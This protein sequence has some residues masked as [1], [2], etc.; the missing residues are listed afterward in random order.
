MINA[1]TTLLYVGTFKLAEYI[2]AVFPYEAVGTHFNNYYSLYIAC[3]SGVIIFFIILLFGKSIAAMNMMKKAYI[4]G[5]VEDTDGQDLVGIQKM[6]QK[7]WVKVPYLNSLY[8]TYLWS[9]ISIPFE[10]YI[11][12]AVLL[13]GLLF[14]AG[15]VLGMPTILSLVISALVMAA[16]ISVINIF[17]ARNQ[18]KITEQLP[19]VLDTMSGALQSGY[20]LLQAF[21]FTAE[22]IDP[23]ARILFEEGVREL[24]YNVP[25]EEVFE[26][27]QEKTTNQELIMVLDGLILQNKMG[28][29]IVSMLQ[30]M[31]E[32]VRQKNKLYKD[33]KVFTSQG[34]FSGLMI[35][36]LWP[37]SALVFY[38]LN[39]S[40][41]T[42]MIENPIGQMLL[43]VS[44]ILEIV[45]FIMIWKIIKI[46]I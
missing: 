2:R 39:K 36:L 30:K 32:W 26:S 37:A 7:F 40:Y 38:K 28:G 13:A 35:M 34:R 10:L 16:Y 41:I 20:S 17:A 31:G 43:G 22:E 8:R 44:L 14:F 42:I 11:M 33:I 18:A 23:P 12:S 24:Q 19:F 3:V 1:Y 46:K 25:L 27:M 29:N 9:N 15:S 21:T 45:G 6:E 4:A 5:Q